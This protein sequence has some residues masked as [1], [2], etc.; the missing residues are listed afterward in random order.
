M[1]PC[2]C[3]EN[4]IKASLSCILQLQCLGSPEIQDQDP[5]HTKLSSFSTYD[6]MGRSGVSK[7]FR[8]LPLTLVTNFDSTIV[9]ECSTSQ[10]AINSITFICEGKVY[11]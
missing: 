10:C 2:Q 11:S 4:I 7:S 9:N 8:K 1:L 6:K 3:N 5:K